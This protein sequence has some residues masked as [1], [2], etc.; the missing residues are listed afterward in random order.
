MAVD[1]WICPE[2]C[3]FDGVDKCKR[4]DDRNDPDTGKCLGVCGCSAFVEIDE[5]A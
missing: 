5:E 4:D 1:Y 3:W 2:C